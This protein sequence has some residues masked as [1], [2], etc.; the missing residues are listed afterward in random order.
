M[1]FVVLKEESDL[2]EYAAL[3]NRFLSIQFPLEYLKRSRVTAYVDENDRILGGYMLV[4]EGPYRVVDSL[5]DEARAREPRFAADKLHQGFEVTGLWMSPAVRDR[6]TNLLFW[7]RMYKDMLTLGRK[8]LVYAYS[9]DKPGLGRL[10]SVAKPS[11]VY[12]GETKMQEGMPEPDAESV[13]VV[14]IFNLARAPFIAPQF[15][16]RRLM[17]R[18]LRRARPA[19]MVPSDYVPVPV[20]VEL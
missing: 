10:Y 4:L 6:R 7:L 17:P 15:L 16:L 14:S 20:R 11:V 1:A 13:E 8:W 12:R 18:R 9:L 2:K 5:P 3:T 19:P